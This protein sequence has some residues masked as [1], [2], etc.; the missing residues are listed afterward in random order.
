MYK[1]I[2][3]FFTIILLLTSCKLEL[4]GELYVA[5]VVDV[6]QGKGTLNTPMNLSFEM[7]SVDKCK[8]DKEEI[9]NILKDYFI[10]FV[11]KDCYSEDFNSFLR[12]GAD[13]PIIMDTAPGDGKVDLSNESVITFSVV[14]GEN[15]TMKFYTTYIALNSPLF[16]SI[17]KKIKDKYY[18]TLKLDKTKI[19]LAINNDGRETEDVRFASA[20]VN[21]KPIVFQQSFK[22]ERRQK[23]DF[24]GSNVTTAAF[25]QN[26]IAYIF[27][28][29]KTK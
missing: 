25:D 2:L 24:L 6:G 23:I 5:D 10:N 3:L 17:S 14:P 16:D 4:D 26:K 11:A 13:V 1:K 18:Q 28:V 9:S 29:V 22:L 12:V 21:G 19:K 15:E 8:E 7:S 20:F 27:T